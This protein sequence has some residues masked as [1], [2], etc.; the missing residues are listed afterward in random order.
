MSVRKREWTTR[1]GEAKEAWIVDYTDAS[2]RH[3]ETFERKKDAEAREAQV[4]VDVAKGV[5]TAPSKSITVA[6]A[7]QDWIS[8]IEGEGRE[9]TTVHRYKEIVR[10]HIVPR[11]G[12]EKLAKLTTPRINAF[13]DELLKAMSRPMAKKVLVALKA[14][15]KDA[16]RRGNVAQNVASDVSITAHGRNKP[17][18]EIGRDIPTRNEIQRIIDAGKPGKGRALL[19]TA[20]LTGMR[21]SE[22]RGLRWSDVDLA[23]RQIHVRQRADR[24]RKI[25]APKSVAGVRTIPIGDM[26]VNTL[27][28]WKLQC[29]KGT[30]NL[31]FPTNVGT[32]EHYPNVV[33]KYFTPALL[34]AGVVT[35]GKPK[36]G[37]LHAFRHFYASWCINRKKDGGLE[38]PPKS[39]QA[40]LG[41]TSIV[42]TL[43]VYGHLFPSHDD[44]AEL[45]AAERAL[46]ATNNS[47]KKSVQH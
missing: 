28:E 35:K 20:A 46:F 27:R 33:Q 21:A 26:V 2:G 4:T 19:M 36:Y 22:L 30:E 14:T 32:V 44:G 40:R 25:G 41:H 45:A 5:H 23:K 13:R 12:N 8:Y 34:A 38:L 29:P 37:G 15:L 39:V 6:Q 42:M 3:I 47:H 7:A 43:D 11:L 1:K 17:K 16:K 18:L 31:V 10:L 9:R 24:Y